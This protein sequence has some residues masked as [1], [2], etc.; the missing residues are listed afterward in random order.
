MN[1]LDDAV[2]RKAS[3]QAPQHADLIRGARASAGEHDGE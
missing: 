1:A 3:G 2:A